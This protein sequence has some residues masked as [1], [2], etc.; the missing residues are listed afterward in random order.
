[1]TKFYSVAGWLVLA[2]VAFVTL[3]PISDRPAIAAPHLERFAAFFL[4]GAVFLLAYPNQIAIVVLRYF[5]CSN[6]RIELP[7]ASLVSAA[8]VAVA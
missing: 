4:L 7:E 3:S 6:S 5:G 2:C 1:M 8:M